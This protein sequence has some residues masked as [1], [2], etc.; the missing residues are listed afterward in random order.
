MAIVLSNA[1]QQLF[2]YLSLI[3]LTLNPTHALE[4]IK[5]S[6][7]NNP[8]AEIT[9]ELEFEREM[10]EYTTDKVGEPYTNYILKD[11][12]ISSSA[13]LNEFSLLDTKNDTLV[14][15]YIISNLDEN[16][17][18]IWTRRVLISDRFRSKNVDENEIPLD[19]MISNQVVSFGLMEIDDQ[20]P[21]QHFLTLKKIGADMSLRFLLGTDDTFKNEL[22]DPLK[23]FDF[24]LEL[25][26]IF[27]VVINQLKFQICRV[28]LDDISV[29]VPFQSITTYRPIFRNPEFA[30]KLSDVC[31]VFNPS[32]SSQSVIMGEAASNDTQKQVEIF[33]L[34]RLI[35]VI[36]AKMTLHIYKEE[37]NISDFENQ[38]N[39][40]EDQ[41]AQER[42]SDNY[43]TTQL[44]AELDFLK[45]NISAFMDNSPQG[46]TKE[47][48]GELFDLMKS[49][50]CE[51]PE[52]TSRAHIENVEE[53][54][55]GQREI[56][57][58]SLSRNILIV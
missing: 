45:T 4:A 52:E 20:E 41:I 38:F 44:N 56:L 18:T 39:D 51:N 40:F 27:R 32:F 2:L 29:R 55:D 37:P 15:Q 36:E 28:S 3:L 13:K 1:S 12:M 7:V 22:S 54:L 30:V 16:E 35:M 53:I 23:R 31:E 34:A 49:M 19:D 46:K 50:L 17:N 10:Q 8:D 25:V 26:R 48:Y 21:N 58:E 33:S 24:Y 11:E 5:S 57:R 9:D 42:T 14:S 43:G 6:V 47:V